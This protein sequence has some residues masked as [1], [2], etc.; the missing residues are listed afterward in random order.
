MT[1]PRRRLPNRRFSESFNVEAQGMKFTATVSRF[2][3]GSL[4]EIF[5]TNHR[6]GSDVS[7]EEV[8][9]A[10]PLATSARSLMR[11]CARAT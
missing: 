9:C 5:L 2:D 7:D 1:S 8:P 6:A 3:D 10:L 4:A 11:H